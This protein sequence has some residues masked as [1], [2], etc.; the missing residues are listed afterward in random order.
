MA[1]ITKA[2]MP[3]LAE[4]IVK[5]LGGNLIYMINTVHL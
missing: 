4:Q 2:E 3:T 1:K 5:C